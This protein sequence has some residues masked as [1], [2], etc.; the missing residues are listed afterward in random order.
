MI[1]DIHTHHTHTD[2]LELSIRNIYPREI[3]QE[4]LTGYYSTGIHPWHLSRAEKDMELIRNNINDPKLL[5]I[6]ECGLDKLSQ[7]P[8]QT[9]EHILIQQVELA[10]EN[11]LPLIIHLVKAQD[12]LISIK[13]DHPTGQAW[14]IHGFRGKPEQAKQ[15][16]SHGFLLSF[17]HLF[18]SRSALLAYQ[19]HS[20]FI[21]TDNDTK[22]S[23]SSNYQMIASSLNISPT[24]LEER[25]YN[26]FLNTFT[27]VKSLSL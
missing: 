26:T 19:E 22:H 8:M 17:G 3:N 1:I 5:A 23:I 11:T 27:K 14:I 25:C 18:N 21:E 2:S 7:Y 16:L 13:R 4:S 20:M 24:T 9:Q 6:G 10:R 15:L 12:L